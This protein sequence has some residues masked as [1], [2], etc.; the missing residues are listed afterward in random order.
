ML[1]LLLD[2]NLVDSEKIGSGVYYFSF[3]S[4]HCVQVSQPTLARILNQSVS[5]VTLTL[6]LRNLT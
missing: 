6:S 3:P 1:K 5:N 2:D 4:K